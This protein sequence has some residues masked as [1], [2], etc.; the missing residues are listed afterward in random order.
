MSDTNHFE[1]IHGP[2]EWLDNG[3]TCYTPLLAIVIRSTFNLP[4]ISFFTKPEEPQQLAYMQYPSGHTIVPHTHRDLY[5]T[6]H[7]T[8][9]TLI[10]RKGRVKL[11]LYDNQSKHVTSRILHSGD[12]VLL[13]NGGHGLTCE[14]PTEMF[15]VKVGPYLGRDADKVNIEQNNGQ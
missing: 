3:Y 14:E 9:E 5:R 8:Q 7:K 2:K 10:I 12:I 13:V 4:G 11:D 1:E 15:E 6:I